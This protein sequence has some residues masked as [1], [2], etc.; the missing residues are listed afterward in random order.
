MYPAGH[1][2]VGLYTYKLANALS[3]R[4]VRVTLF[5]GDQCEL[6]HFPAKFKRTRLLCRPRAGISLSRWQIVNILDMIGGYL[7]MSY[8][9]Y[10][11]VKQDRPEVVHLH[12]FMF[13]PIEWYLLNRLR[14]TGSRIVL[15]V[16]NVLPTSFY[17]GPFT[18]LERGILQY[19]Y[20]MADRLIVHTKMN[21]RQL[22]EN[23][24]I[25]RDKVAVIPHGEYS[26]AQTGCDTSV[27]EARHR[28][29]LTEKQRVILF[30]GYIKRVKGV[31]V[32]L[33]GF[34]QIAE[35]FED[36]VLIIAGSLIEGESFDDCH[37]IVRSMKHRDRVKLFIEYVAHE[38]IP[39]FF[40]PADVVVLPYVD[41][42]AQSGVAHIAQ[43]FGKAV[44]ATDVGGLPEVIEDQET[45]LIVPPRDGEALAEAIS[46]LLEHEE[47]RTRM[48]RRARERAMERFSWDSIAEATIERAYRAHQ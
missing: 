24:S 1:A 27:S 36:V 25:E 39:I 18:G 23:F 10:S 45:G 42:Y 46:Y 34:D 5:G 47:T 20:S 22:L 44:V 33:R 48:G 29:S 32:L 3:D 19:I 13:Y 40:L 28:L 7:C 6:D 11:S 17:L 4:G 31:D 21:E 2:G 38:E 8:K 9:L 26:L 37:G 43:G 41:F 14:R 16:H 15:T 30:F 12:S 35:K